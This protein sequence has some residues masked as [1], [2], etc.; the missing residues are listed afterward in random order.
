MTLVSLFVMHEKRI[1]TEQKTFIIIFL[2]NADFSFLL[3]Y[4]HKRCQTALMVRT[5][6][7]KVGCNLFQSKVLEVNDGTYFSFG[8]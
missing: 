1:L 8:A 3:W 4:L 2:F 7:S 5:V 6:C